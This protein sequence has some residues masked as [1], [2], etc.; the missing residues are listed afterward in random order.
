MESGERVLVGVDVGGTFTDFVTWVGGRPRVHKRATTPEDQS[1]A[2]GAGLTE[3]AVPP[4]ADLVHGTTTATNAL[5]ERRG[6][7]VALLTTEGFTDVLAL[8]RQARRELYRLSPA[9]PAPLVPAALR[10]PVPE[11]LAADGRVV[12]PLDEAAVRALGERL[13]AQAVESVAVVLLHSYRDPRHERRVAALLAEL[14]PGVPV[15]ASV[16]VLPEYREYERTATTVV[17]A[18]VRPLVGRYLARLQGVVGRRRV[19]VMQSNGGTIGLDT[20]AAQAARL[21]LSGPAGGVVGALA[22]AGAALGT[23]APRVLTFDMGGTSTDVALCPGALP[24]TAESTI[25]D[26]PLRLPAIDIH[27]VG[28][29]GGSLARVDAAGALH[30]GPRSAGAVPGP[31][32]YG[33]GGT[34]P[35]VTDANLALGRLDPAHFLGGDAA[36][37]LDPGAARAALARLGQALGLAEHPAERAALGVLRVADATMERALRTVSVERGYDPADFVLLPFGGAGPLH[38]CALAAALGIRRVLVP[39]SPGVLSALG[40]LVADRV[41]D[42][43]QSLLRSLDALRQDPAPLATALDALDEQTAAVLRAE[44][45]AAPVVTACLDLRYVGQSY[46]LTVP[47]DRPIDAAALGRARAAFH[48]THAQRYGHAEPGLPV[49]VVTVRVRGVGPGARPELPREPLGPAD[50]SAARLAERP[51]WF[52]PDAPTATPGYDRTRLQ[53]GARLRGPA[54]VFQYDT[55]TVVPPGWTGHVDEWRNLWLARAAAPGAGEEPER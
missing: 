32:C 2:I 52:G 11:R 25:A 29:G 42:R 35:T 54:V 28:A 49:E 18:Y 26:L 3:L 20:A 41:F 22:V 13:R 7:R 48:A 38:A 44:G 34:E 53:P 1:R 40:L 50:A 51:V 37:R 24:W 19:S 31:A 6:A 45:V 30:V 33:R 10:L 8:G 27:T 55:T 47:L 15:T 39:P 9:E 12:R 36:A 5:L 14:L 4:G 46:E 16:D 43:S 17:N 23:D 21:V